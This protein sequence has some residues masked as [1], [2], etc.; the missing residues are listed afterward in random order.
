MSRVWP[1]DY[2]DGWNGI[3]TEQDDGKLLTVVSHESGKTW[4][5]V[6]ETILDAIELCLRIKREQTPTIIIIDPLLDYLDFESAWSPQEEMN[7]GIRQSEQA[8]QVAPDLRG[9][10]QRHAVDQRSGGAGD[11]GPAREDPDPP[12]GD[13]GARH[14][15][16]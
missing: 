3:I 14:S 11:A 12:S 7:R 16:A 1:I 5:A 9:V 15:H 4:Q 13:H 6:R 8:L 10:A 2:M